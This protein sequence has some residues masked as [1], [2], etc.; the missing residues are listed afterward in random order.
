MDVVAGAV[1]HPALRRRSRRT[2]KSTHRSLAFLGRNREFPS[3]ISI[4]S[5]LI[6]VIALTPP[7]LGQATMSG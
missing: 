5:P 3:I 2:A 4:E 6:I 1:E 7:E